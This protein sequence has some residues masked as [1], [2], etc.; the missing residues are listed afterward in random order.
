MEKIKG[1]LST[2][3]NSEKSL[4]IPESN[5][6]TDYLYRSHSATVAWLQRINISNLLAVDHTLWSLHRPHA[7]FLMKIMK[8]QKSLND[9][10]HNPM[11]CG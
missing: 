3:K 11:E 7:K 8:S 5:R 4:I 2:Q 1:W 6:P 10:T 9:H